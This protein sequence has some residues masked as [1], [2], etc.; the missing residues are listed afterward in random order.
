MVSVWID[1]TYDFEA[2]DNVELVSPFYV[3]K[4]KKVELNESQLTITS[5]DNSVIITL[6]D[7]NASKAIVGV[8][9]GIFNN[10]K[11]FDYL[12]TDTNGQIIFTGLEGTY[13]FEITYPGNPDSYKATSMNKTFTFTK[14]QNTSPSNTV[15]AT[16]K[17]VKKS[18]KITA[19][20]ATFKKSKKVKKY[21]ITLKSGK[22]P[23]SKV[24]V[25]LKVKGKTYKATTNVK[26]KATFKIT[27]LIKKGTYKAK[28]TFKGNKYY[29]SAGKTIKIKVK[30]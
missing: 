7:V 9:V 2:S 28:I 20:K 22:N 13:S 23:I 10:G 11:V 27:K 25:T 26:G 18:T 15:P 1:C 16:N 30:G 14:N 12:D 17:I 6:T 19:K 29:K 4:T 21:T 3:N 24:K 5:K 8:E